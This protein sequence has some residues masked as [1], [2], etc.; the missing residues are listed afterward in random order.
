MQ[1]NNE[2]TKLETWYGGYLAM[3]PGYDGEMIVAGGRSNAKN[4]KDEVGQTWYLTKN[5]DGWNLKNEV[6]LYLCMVP[7]GTITVHL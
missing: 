4:K 3:V 7:D 6:G 1:E 5:G 2:V